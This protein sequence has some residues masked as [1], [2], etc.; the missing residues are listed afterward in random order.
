MTHPDLERELE[1][2]LHPGF[3]CG[4]CNGACTSVDEDGTCSGCGGDPCDLR[5]RVIPLLAAYVQRKLGEGIVAEDA[6]YR[7]GYR[8][9]CDIPACNCG[10]QWT[11]G[12]HADARLQEID[13]ALYPRTNGKTI[14]T[15]VNELVADSEL[16]AEVE[17]L[18]P[19]RGQIE[20]L[21]CDGEYS[22]R[23]A[24]L[25]PP[26]SVRHSGLTPTL[27]DALRK[28]VESES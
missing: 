23:I 5:P 21:W 3:W 28:L 8:K 17:K 25:E 2:L 15:A 14:L 20:I 1:E 4:P 11:H 12:G 26:A 27:R 24:L 18:L 6:L 16:L 9:S 22:A 19:R 7:K 13:E 10:D